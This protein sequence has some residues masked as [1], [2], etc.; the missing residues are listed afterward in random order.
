MQASEATVCVVIAARNAAGTVDAAIRS[1]LGQAEVAEV[2]VV[3]DASTDGTQMVARQSD[4]GSDRL[5]ILRLEENHGPAFAR[6]RAIAASCAPLIGILDADDVFLPGRF[7]PLLACD[8]WD[9][10]ADDIVFIGQSDLP[11]DEHA[12]ER[13]AGPPFFLDLAGFVDGNVSRRG[14]ERGEIG[15]LKP[16]MR[17]AF[18][19]D[20]GLAYREELR[21][22]EDYDLYARA[23]LCGARYKV[24]PDCGY[25]AVVR[26]DSL[27]GRHRT[28]DLFRL[29]QA[30]RAI[31]ELGG[32]SLPAAARRALGRHERQTRAKH[33]LR[34]FLDTKA[35]AGL[36]AATMEALGDPRTLPSTVKV[37]SPTSWLRSGGRGPLRTASCA[38]CSAPA[39]PRVSIA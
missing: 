12:V 35:A 15:F 17:R 22:G 21:L 4:D 38:L 36:P 30:D 5:R 28:E 27:S 14:A 10:I 24:L 34:R 32:A 13:A 11:L 25:A 39:D 19:A 7:A 29:W 9:F 3:D 26:P 8:D 31:L 37:S 16:V 33:A 23:L 20:H 6:N 18:L 1:A 2:I